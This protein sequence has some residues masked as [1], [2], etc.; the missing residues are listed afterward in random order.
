M[1][2]TSLRFP[3]PDTAYE[4]AWFTPTARVNFCEEN[5]LVTPYIAEFV[6][7]ITNISYVIYAYYGVRRLFR[8]NNPHAA[9][10]SLPYLGLAAVGILSAV[11][12][13]TLTYA[14]QMADDTSMIL[15]TA[16]VLHR[17]FA[18]G[19]SAEWTRN[20]GV[21]LALGFVVFAAY[22]AWTDELLVHFLL[23]A[24]MTAAVGV[25]TS[26]LI[27]ERER[28]KYG[29]G[30]ERVGR[31]KALAWVG[32]VCSAVGYALWNVDM[33]LCDPLVSVRRMV[34][35]PAGVLLELHGW[36]H[37]LT[38]I[39]AYVFMALVEVLTT[40]EGG[41]REPAPFA[42]PVDAYLRDVSGEKKRS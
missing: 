25:R 13:A 38:A 8:A 37:I 17:A 32:F 9:L 28:G 40:E 1:P 19:R 33:H 35:L 29:G 34:G 22:H 41:E 10:L 27:G 4:P 11:F 31:L 21:G 42:W 2:A 3:Y 15:A 24:G 23:F 30:R 39:G 7:T 16:L 12:H 6:N 36:W 18:H 14:G 5:Y 26:G 20:T